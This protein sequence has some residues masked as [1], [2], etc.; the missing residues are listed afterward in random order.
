MNPTDAI[1]FLA[2]LDL[3]SFVLLFWYLIV[4]DFGR[5]SLSLAAVIVERWLPKRASVPYRGPVSILLVGHNEG[6]RLEKCVRSLEEQDYPAATQIVVVDDGSTDGT[7]GVGRRL[8]TERRIQ[9]FVGTG[10]RGGKASALNLG[11]RYCSHPVVVTADIDTSFDRDAIAKLVEPFGDPAVGAVAGN[12]GVRNTYASI[13]T[14]LQSIQYLV[15]ISLGRRFTSMMGWLM[16]VSGAFGAYRRSAVQ[17]VGGWDVGPGDDSNLTTKV[18]RSGWEVRFAHGAWALTDVPVTAGALVRQQ[19]RWNRSIVR[20]RARK[21]RRAFNP[22]DAHFSLRDA[23]AFSNILF[24]Q[25]ILSISFFVYLLWLL[26]A[27]TDIAALVITT[28]S[29]V[30]LLE[31]LA[32]LGIGSLFYGERVRPGLLLYAP[33]STLYKGYFLRLVRVVAYVDELAFRRSYRDSFYPTKVRN[34]VEQF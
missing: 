3:G 21:F 20:N 9:A 16:I 34:S 29:V 12:L 32:V 33:L 31:D 7:A 5:Y 19:L 26:T 24:F 25:V 1:A 15:S 30:Y 6:R 17:V 18:R 23:L 28:V 14:A 2:Q 13:L 27:H 11:F 22:F 10:I 4:F 8:K